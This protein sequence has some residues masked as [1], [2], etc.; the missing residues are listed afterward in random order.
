MNIPDKEDIIH[1]IF[2]AVTSVTEGINHRFGKTIERA[3]QYRNRRAQPLNCLA[4]E[5]R[6]GGTSNLLLLRDCPALEIA[7]FSEPGNAAARLMKNT[8]DFACE[9]S[10]LIRMQRPN[11]SE[12]PAVLR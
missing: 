9:L 10:Y 5:R 6:T 8:C 4:L 12:C 1:A 7:E 2:D 11:C 3:Q